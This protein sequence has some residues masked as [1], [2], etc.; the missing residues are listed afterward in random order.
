[1]GESDVFEEE[2]SNQVSPWWQRWSFWV[3]FC[4]VILCSL[5]LWGW[6]LQWF[7]SGAYSVPQV[8]AA[9][10][11][12]VSE[13]TLNERLS[14]YDDD[15]IS[16]LNQAKEVNWSSMEP[17]LQPFITEQLPVSIMMSETELLKW[18][19]ADTVLQAWFERDTS[20][21]DYGLFTGVVHPDGTLVDP[22]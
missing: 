18:S 16:V 10:F 3:V 8:R 15:S 22:P 17:A 5:G 13:L 12:T 2:H 4:V 19:R 21:Q 9:V 1:M 6:K 14:A 20:L 11:P 7:D